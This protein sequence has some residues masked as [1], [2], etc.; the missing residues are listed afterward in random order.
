M[1]SLMLLYM[2][3][4][5][6]DL[7]AAVGCADMVPPENGYVIRQEDGATITCNGS[8]QAWHL[9]CKDTE[10]IGEYGDCVPGNAHKCAC[11]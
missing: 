11:I 1:L 10:W 9:V 6:R 8:S 7:L 4:L 5:P 3:L 2:L